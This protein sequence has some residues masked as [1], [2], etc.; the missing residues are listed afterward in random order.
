MNNIGKTLILGS[1]F[2]TAIFAQNRTYFA[3]TRNAAAYNFGN[4]TP[5][6][7][8]KITTAPATSGAG[9]TFSV[10]QG[11]LTAGDGTVFCPFFV[12]NSVLLGGPSNQETVTITA[13]SCSQSYGGTTF[14]ATTTLVH[15]ISE[16]IVSAS[17]G[18]YE[19]IAAQGSGG[20]VAIDTGWANAGGTNA[21]IQAAPLPASIVIDD[22]RSIGTSY[23]YNAYN[24]LTVVS[25]P[26]AYTANTVASSA[27]V[28]GTW[29]NTGTQ[30]IYVCATYITALGGESL[31]S[32]TYNATNFTAAKAI[33]AQSPA[34]SAG[35]V[36][37]RLYFSVPAGSYANSYL[38]PI[39]SSVCT[40]TTLESVVPACAIGSA[41]TV[42]NI[43]VNTAALK[44]AVSSAFP[45]GVQQYT[46]LPSAFGFPTTWLP[47]A[48]DVVSSGANAD[49]AVI[50]IPANFFNQVGKQYNLCAYGT[51]TAVNTAVATV[52]W[53]LINAYAQTP[54]TLVSFAS[55]ALTGAAYNWNTC[56]EIQTAVAGASG[57]LEVH[58]NMDWG[59]ASTGV[60]A[61]G[62]LT[63]GN[64]GAVTAADLT[65]PTFLSMNLAAAT[66]NMSHFAVR[67]ITLTPI[68]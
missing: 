39:T 55:P 19:A 24:N 37:Y 59:L 31:C 15:G 50:N 21:I 42:A 53:T 7:A 20:V 16:P 32:P 45:A 60:M 46:A 49:A 9:T 26:V 6:A 18:L 56:V 40:L 4:I 22:N 12:N 14:T 57:T 61:A 33:V 44:P 63:D 5:I 25:A 17:F 54:N 28:T 27:S 29:T 11:Y 35:A 10:D 58:G 38:A 51:S 52:K 34:A 41:A 30:A 43:V 1:L 65:K 62:Q 36:G 2:A 67:Q 23:W 3:G 66:A 68:N 8:P 64:T 13:A 47:F 48:D